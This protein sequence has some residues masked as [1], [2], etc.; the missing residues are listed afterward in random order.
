MKYKLPLTLFTA[1]I[2][3]LAGCAQS[4]KPS[5]DPTFSVK[6]IKGVPFLAEDGKAM[7]GRM[8]YGSTNGVRYKVIQPEWTTLSM[9]IT[10]KSD[11]LNALAR[12][13]FDGLVK[14]ISIRQINLVD[15]T[16]NKTHLLISPKY[17]KTI[18]RLNSSDKK[19]TKITHNADEIFIEKDSDASRNPRFFISNIPLQKN[20]KYRF[21]VE[22]KYEKAGWSD[23]V[24]ASKGEII[25]ISSEKVFLKQFKHVT[26]AN[27]NVVTIPI[28]LLRDT[29]NIKMYEEI[30]SKVFD[31]VIA[32]NPNV[33]IIPRIGVDADSKWLDQ[34]PDSEMRNHD[35]KPTT[36]MSRGNFTSL[37]RF[38]SVSSL[39]YREHYGECLR[40]T[41]LFL[42]SK[43][44]KNIMGY[45]PCGANT[46]EWFYAQSP[47]PIPS[48]YDPSTLIAWR[49]WLAKK[50]QTAEALQTAWNK[51][52]V[53][54]ETATVPTY[55]ERMT[56]IS[57]VIDPAK[58]QNVIDFNLFLN[59]EMADTVIH[60]GKV[61]KDTTNGKKLSLTFYGYG[62]EFAAGAQSPSVTGHFA[63]RKVLSSPYI[64]MISGPVSYS[65]RGKGGEKKYMSAVESCTNAGKLWCDEDDNRTY[66]IWG[67]GS[68]LLVADP[69]Q[70]TQK[71]SI[72]VM[73]RNL[74]QQ[75]IR[76]TPSWWMD[77][78]GTGWYDDPVLWKQIELTKKAERDMIRRPQRYNPPIA[79][80]YD[81]TSMNYVGRPSGV[82]TGGIMGCARRYV[83]YTGIPSGQYLLDDIL[84]NRASPKLNVF[85]NVVALDADQRKKMREASERSASIYCWA[86]GYA[87][88][89]N[90]KLSVDAIKEAT[91]FEVKALTTPTSTIVSST[92]EGLKAG[93][94]EKFGY[95]TN[96]KMTLFF[97][98]VIEAGDIV[99]AKYETGDPAVVLRKTGKNPQ[100]FMGATIISEEILRYM[101]NE[102]GIHSYTKQ[103]A[104]V[105]A[106][107]AYVSITAHTKE[108]HTVD[109]KTDKK[110]Y[111]VFTGEELGQGPV[112]NFDMDVGEVKFVRI[113]KRNP[114]R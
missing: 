65:W 108:T 110:I 98:P 92:P 114:K 61:I 81:E 50:Y 14:K 12:M 67:S 75:I 103:P 5:D 24:M 99:L 25:G 94:P 1:F 84:E 48:G 106:N 64:D 68:I 89:T 53:S 87:D 15:L 69:G 22:L 30:A 33:R 104:S 2:L 62:F 11:D 58:S 3:S 32:M 10:P 20:K 77:L 109:F 86:T 100:M 70:K 47:G 93:L 90:K 19:I 113:G 35:G 55:Q 38:A 49:K 52:D 66:L 78:F 112:L 27:V 37:Q 88:K 21:D 17:P 16:D 46:G 59:D 18:K 9:D 72:D 28:T 54:P 39:K 107:G 31:P 60:F 40:N 85:L 63:M 6:K 26:K 7:R 13:S 79:L 57:Y 45:H 4:D 73:R 29:M 41:I 51:K 83:N 105:Y 71:D 43:Y 42:E 111:D 74:S 91:G 101:A 23:M 34:N 102:C 76:N 95:Q 8:F 82:T 36:R 80:V 96:H 44:G 56:D 97:S